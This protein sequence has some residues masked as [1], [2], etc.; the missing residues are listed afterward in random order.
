MYFSGLKDGNPEKVA[1]FAHISSIW[2]VSTHFRKNQ[3]KI[4]RSTAFGFSSTGPNTPLNWDQF[5]IHRKNKIGRFWCPADTKLEYFDQ[6]RLYLD[7][8]HIKHNTNKGLKWYVSSLN[9]SVLCLA[10]SNPKQE[11]ETKRKNSA[12]RRLLTE[13]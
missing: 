10:K 5:L 7:S 4:T 2:T 11:A 13:K 6:K 3:T 8:V 9:F 1:N 12:K